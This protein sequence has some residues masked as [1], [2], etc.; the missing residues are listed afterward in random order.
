MGKMSA[1]SLSLHFPTFR[2]LRRRPAG[3]DGF[4]RWQI[5]ATVVG[6][7]VIVVL[8]AAFL[9]LAA[10]ERSAEERRT[11][12]FAILRSAATAGQS[13][14]LLLPTGTAQAQ[15]QHL[16]GTACFVLVGALSTGFLIV[17]ISASFRSRLAKAKSAEAQSRAIID[18]TLGGGVIHA[19]SRPG[20]GATF[21]IF[22]PTSEKKSPHHPALPPQPVTDSPRILVIDDEEAICM[23]VTCALEPHGYEVT[24]TIDGLSAIAAYETA[25]REGRPYRLVIS[26]LA[27]PGGLS[28]AQ[29]IV[30]L[31]EIDPAVRAIA[32]SGYAN[33]PVLSRFADYG[34]VD[35]LAKP[36]ELDALARKVAEVLAA[37]A[38]PT[39]HYHDFEQ[40]KTA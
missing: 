9:D 33:D 25:L 13:E 8:G 23:L 15:R 4:S 10:H 39:V 5:R 14:S 21:T 34:F 30:R 17:S 3:E 38:Q 16:F 20:E 29:T 2:R 31:R 22:L 27:M 26:D 12:E 7:V 11:R 6:I 1:R 19:E 35:M 24:E 32:S 36:Y 40:R 37:P 18:Q 28:G